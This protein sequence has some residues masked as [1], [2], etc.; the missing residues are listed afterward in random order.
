MRA[1]RRAAWSP[2]ATCPGGGVG[3]RRRRDASPRVRFPRARKAAKPVA[4]EPEPALSAKVEEGV[5]GVLRF[6]GGL[7]VVLWRLVV[8][9]RRLVR[10]ADD[11]G[12]L[13]RAVPPVSFATLCTFAATSA[14]RTLML[15]LM[16]IVLGSM[17]ACAPE[18][19][20]EP[21]LPKLGDLLK[22][23]SVD[24]LLFTGIPAVL[25]MLLLLNGV[26]RALKPRLPGGGDR[27]VNIGL[28][29]GGFQYLLA[30]AA[31]ALA[32][33][34]RFFDPSTPNETSVL[35]DRPLLAALAVVV[36]WPAVL[37]TLWLMSELPPGRRPWA[38]RP[39]ASTALLAC[40]GLAI[41]VA[42][43]AAGLLVAYP[44]ARYDFASRKAPQPLLGVRLVS[45]VL[46]PERASSA[47]I[48]LLV[49]NHAAKTMHL[50]P[51]LAE[52]DLRAA[53]G[54]HVYRTARVGDWQGHDAR[55]VTLAPGASAWLAFELDEGGSAGP[56][57]G[58]QR[59][60]DGRLFGAWHDADLLDKMLQE[61]TIA[62]MELF[63]GDLSY[64]KPGDGPVPRVCLV[65][66][67]GD[68]SREAV[69]AFIAR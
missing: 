19:Q 58:P 61:P 20:R 33:P 63:A 40:A 57:I 50:L 48:T 62:V 55:M 64:P 6:F 5:R 46:A 16:V 30:T 3:M 9:P 69:Y 59:Y 17:R 7:A 39:A 49:E 11:Q 12:R 8:T 36:L 47:P 4:V 24:D 32:L 1:V 65:R 31:F 25:L 10:D 18:S 67:D 14:I 51:D 35:G 23:P 2:A 13:A 26:A 52:F 21:E 44:L 42:S 54:R 22:M 34:R 53:D 60:C 45:G 56:A 37:Y 27:F 28:Y 68:R 43:L 66:V 29:V 15:S 41:S 38:T